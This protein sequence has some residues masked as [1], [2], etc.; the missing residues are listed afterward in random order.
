MPFFRARTPGARLLT[1][2]L[3][4]RPAR[5]A[6][7]CS[8]RTVTRTSR[9]PGAR[10]TPR[11][12]LIR[13]LPQAHRLPAII[14]TTPSLLFSTSSRPSSASASSSP[15]R[16]FVPVLARGQHPSVIARLK[17][18]NV[19][20]QRVREAWATLLGRGGGDDGSVR[21]HGGGGGRG[22]GGKGAAASPRAAKGGTVNGPSAKQ[23]TKDPRG[24]G[25]RGGKGANTPTSIPDAWKVLRAVLRPSV[26]FNEPI[27]VESLEDLFHRLCRS[28]QWNSAEECFRTIERLGEPS[29]DPHAGAT[30]P[31]SPRRSATSPSSSLASSSSS[32]SSSSLSSTPASGSGSGSGSGGGGGGRSSV[33]APGQIKVTT[34]TLLLKIYCRRVRRRASDRR[35]SPAATRALAQAEAVFESMVV[36]GRENK[37]R[38]EE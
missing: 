30:S 7:T 36:S 22:G 9:P 27:P 32:S 24:G 2:L 20:N 16:N 31:H 37:R 38:D 23:S 26:R 4:H 3:H 28:R 15:A 34:Y 18:I 5:P 11:G 35:L 13:P 6:M 10:T 19:G 25:A 21:N 29:G 1:Q 14:T 33:L 12:G 8:F 17:E